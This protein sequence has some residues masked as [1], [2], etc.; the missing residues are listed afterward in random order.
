MSIQ[1]FKLDRRPYIALV[2]RADV[3]TTPDDPVQLAIYA[4]GTVCLYWPDHEQG[5]ASFYYGFLIWARHR[6]WARDCW[7]LVGPNCLKDRCG[8]FAPRPWRTACFPQRQS[9]GGRCKTTASQWYS[10]AS[11]NEQASGTQIN[12]DE[13][14]FSGFIG[15]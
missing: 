9:Q 4:P 8:G 10:R 3:E 15:G 11:P 12:A 5:A 6:F 2:R 14:R 1:P 7:G 13:R